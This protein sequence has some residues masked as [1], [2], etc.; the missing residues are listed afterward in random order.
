M[1]RDIV[2]EMAKLLSDRVLEFHWP[3][4]QDRLCA[5]A[6]LPCSSATIAEFVTCHHPPCKRPHPSRAWFGR[7]P[8]V[9][10]ESVVVCFRARNYILRI[11]IPHGALYFNMHDFWSRR[12]IL[13][14]KDDRQNAPLK[15]WF[16]K[17]PSSFDVLSKF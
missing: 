4:S 12:V 16:P 1:S 8:P 6:R 10:C 15:D 7:I 2:V 13:R 11:L 14:R 17:M 9:A 5:A 3:L